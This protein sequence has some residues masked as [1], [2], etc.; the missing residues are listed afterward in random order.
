MSAARSPHAVIVTGAS[1]G[2]GLAIAR[3]Y[4]RDGVNLVLNGRD[5]AKLAASAALLGAVSGYALVAGSISEP[6]TA[7]RLIEAAEARFGGAD[8]LINNA[9]IFESKPIAGYTLKDVDE[10][11]AINLRGTILVTQAM[12]AHLRARRAGG[13]IVN[14]TSAISLAPMRQLPAAVPNATKGALNTFTRSLALE[15]A[16]EGIRVHAVAPG[17]ISTPLLGEEATR[18]ERLGALQPVG[19]LG[20]AADVARAV[21]LLAAQAYATGVVLPIDGGSSLGHW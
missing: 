19:Q 6:E 21:Q 13:A 1:S 10:V 15:L 12:V 2:I 7:R 9:G 17:L 3:A 18:Q 16:A 14:I 11:L 5:E 20:E 4:A 8:V